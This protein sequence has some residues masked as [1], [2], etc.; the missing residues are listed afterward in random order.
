[1][2]KLPDNWDEIQPADERRISPPAD[3]YLCRIIR[4]EED[5][6]RLKMQLDIDSGD[7][8]G[9]FKDDYDDRAS[10]GYDKVYWGLNYSVPL[11][12]YDPK[13][14]Y[15][16]ARL[17]KRFVSTLEATTRNFKLPND[18]EYNAFVGKKFVALV[19]VVEKQSGD[20][21]YKNYRVRREYTLKD[22]AEGNIPPA[23]IED[24]NGNRRKVTDPPPSEEHADLE[25]VDDVDIPF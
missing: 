13:H 8:A 17:F 1:M 22:K 10:R 25:P 16:F 5:N 3:A 9:Y 6:Q 4:A 15:F 21:V 19:D 24:V 2:P 7:F 18:Y 14:G 11:D 12:F 23:E 20:R